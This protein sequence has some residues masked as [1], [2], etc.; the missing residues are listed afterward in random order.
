MKI[1]NLN[2]IDSEVFAVVSGKGGS[3]KTMITAILANLFDEN[4]RNNEDKK[5]L[6]VDADFATGGLSYYMGLKTVKNISKGLTNFLSGNEE[7]TPEFINKIAQKMNGFE[8]SYFIGVGNHRKFYKQHNSNDF[9]NMLP[10]FINKAKEIFDVIIFDCRGG[11]DSESL[12]VCKE[13]N[14][15]ILVVETD[16]TSFQATQHLV[17]ILSDNDISDKLCGFIINKVF[18]NPQSIARNGTSIF[19]TQYLGSV[20][21]DLEATRSFLI[22][23]IPQKRSYFYSQISYAMCKLKDN[24]R[25]YSYFREME[26]IDFQKLNTTNNES[27]IGGIVLSFIILSIGLLIYLDYNTSRELMNSNYLS[28]QMF[29]IL[30]TLGVI[31][32]IEKIRK[33]IGKAILWY[34][35]GISKILLKSHS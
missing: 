12:I 4:F 31:S 20:P 17:D 18:D 14:E 30:V 10:E 7:I 29:I 33:S 26:F 34:F 6:I 9:Q 2:N 11:I 23:E 5:I 25:N 15:I 22:G 27:V 32:G 28:N 3:G 19:K 16:T 35:R 21:F 13:V 24:F 8:Q 1:N